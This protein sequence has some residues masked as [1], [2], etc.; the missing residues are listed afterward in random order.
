M[1]NTRR[2]RRAGFTLIELLVVV[3][4]IALLISILLPSLTCARERA[5]TVK[6][7]SLMRG[8]GNGL[9]TYYTENNE[10]IP[11]TNTTGVALKATGGSAVASMRRHFM[12]VQTFDWMTPILRYDTDLGDN[13]AKRFRTMVNYYSCPSQ[14][15]LSVDLL[16]GLGGTPDRVDFEAES[17]AWTPLSYLMPV[18]FQYWGQQDANV[19]LAPGGRRG[20]LA[21]VA[22][23]S[24]EV[25]VP[26]Y[27]SRRDKIGQP[28][29]KIA[30]ADGT[31]FLDRDGILDFDVSP[32]PT[33]FGSFTSSGAW[34]AG[35][36]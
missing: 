36:R 17:G 21:Q 32:T 2:G 35:M 11:G 8:F 5:R 13:R 28:S 3:A 27:R 29:G 19:V 15:G 30:V 10:W 25:V 6:C 34:W 33:F 22:P 24:W 9:E 14:A 26:K 18:H 20:V 7:G 31:R 23:A 1:R 16:F 12:P 4:I